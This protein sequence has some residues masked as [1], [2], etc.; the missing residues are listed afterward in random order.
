VAQ[1]RKKSFFIVSVDFP[2]CL[3]IGTPNLWFRLC[4]TEIIAYKSQEVSL[5]I[6]G[7]A[8]ISLTI[9]RK[10]KRTIKVYLF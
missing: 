10:C 4:L 2:A 3:Q 5:P 6:G 7:F 1:N 9:Q 8:T